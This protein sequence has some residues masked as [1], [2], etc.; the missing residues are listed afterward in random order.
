MSHDKKF[1]TSCGR[2]RDTQGGE[3]R[4]TGKSPRWVCKSCIDRKSPSKFAS[5]FPKEKRELARILNPFYG[6]E[7]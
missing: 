3:I 1:C 5:P 6:R 2:D 7:R 4:K